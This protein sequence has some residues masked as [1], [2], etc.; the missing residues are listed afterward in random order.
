VNGL[1][2]V[3]NR[4]HSNEIEGFRGN[5]CLYSN[6]TGDFPPY[7]NEFVS[8]V[9]GDPLFET[10]LHETPWFKEAVSHSVDNLTW[11]IGRSQI[12]KHRYDTDYC[13]LEL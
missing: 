9:T 3:Y 1:T 2:A 12:S 13:H 4:G 8:E 5:F 7:Y 10:A 6:E 11:T